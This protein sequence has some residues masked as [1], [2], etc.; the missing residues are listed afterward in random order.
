M[1]T[2]GFEHLQLLAE[3][4][5]LVLKVDNLR[6]LEEYEVERVINDVPRA[7]L[8]H[9]LEFLLYHDIEENL[10]SLTNAIE[11][12]VVSTFLFFGYFHLS[13]LSDGAFAF[14]FCCGAPLPIE[15]WVQHL[16]NNKEALQE[17][18]DFG[19]IASQLLR[20]QPA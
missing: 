9:L 14:A 15:L 10:S 8:P 13:D 7:I 12:L 2:L 17:G 3:V 16:K 6:I 5:L 4:L 20:I 11:E 18:C 19:R 1:A